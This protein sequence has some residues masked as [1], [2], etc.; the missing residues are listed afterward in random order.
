MSPKRTTRTPARRKA[1]GLAT[2]NRNTS[3]RR[4]HVM[5]ENH[6]ATLTSNSSPS[7]PLSTVSSDS[8]SHDP[9]IIPAPS[10]RI[11]VDID[12]IHEFPMLPSGREEYL[13]R[14]GGTD[15]LVKGLDT[16]HTA[17]ENIFKTQKEEICSRMH[18]I[19]VLKEQCRKYQ[20]TICLS[21]LTQE[22]EHRCPGCENLAWDPQ[23][24]IIHGRAYVGFIKYFQGT[25]EITFNLIYIF[26][27][28][29]LVM[30]S[31]MLEGVYAWIQAT[32]YVSF[33]AFD[34][35]VKLNCPCIP[36]V[37]ISPSRRI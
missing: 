31:F 35:G 5:M 25:F 23:I 1:V 36:G 26:C 19:R 4:L 12:S 13:K 17:S 18:Q 7:S 27:S 29:S 32:P 6:S 9:L 34:R 14:Q 37:L 20:E 8:A 21:K 3:T 24:L 11:P 2:Q 33:N 28:L 15:E 10:A 22:R 30:K 16:L